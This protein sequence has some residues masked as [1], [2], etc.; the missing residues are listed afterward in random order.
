MGALSG[1]SA[2]RS[3]GARANGTGERDSDEDGR[4]KREWEWKR[5]VMRC[6][7]AEE[8]DWKI[9]LEWHRGATRDR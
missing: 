2:G 5:V 4:L 6:R 8:L 7:P 3:N 9:S 1:R